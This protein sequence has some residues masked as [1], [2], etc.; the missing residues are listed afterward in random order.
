YHRIYHMEIQDNTV[1]V[2]AEM[3]RRNEAILEEIRNAGYEGP[4]V[5]GMDLDVF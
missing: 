5:N 2:G 3:A 1:D 4:V